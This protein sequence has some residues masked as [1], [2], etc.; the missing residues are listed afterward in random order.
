MHLL[1]PSDPFDP[2]RPDEQYLEEYEAVLAAGLRASLFSFED[3]ESGSFK[4]RPPS[5]PAS[6]CCIAA[7]C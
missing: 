7:G 1:Y 3:F 6:K 2:K 4:A 5:K